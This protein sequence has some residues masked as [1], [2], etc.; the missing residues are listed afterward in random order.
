MEAKIFDLKRSRGIS[1]ERF[2]QG[3]R[4][5]V[6]LLVVAR[7]FGTFDFPASA[8]SKIDTQVD[9]PRALEEIWSEISNFIAEG[10]K[11]GNDKLPLVIDAFCKAFDIKNANS[12]GKQTLRMNNIDIFRRVSY[13]KIDETLLD[14]VDMVLPPQPWPKGVHKEVASKLSITHALASDAIQ[15]LILS[16]R[17]SE[18]IDGEVVSSGH[19]AELD[20]GGV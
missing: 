9:A 19:T 4:G 2:N 14:Q 3:W 8:I 6:S 10:A 7:I 16:G 1:R 17:R 12:V 5:L 15:K 13:K 20:T 11:I 18:Q